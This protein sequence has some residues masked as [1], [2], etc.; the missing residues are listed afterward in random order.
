MITESSVIKLPLRMEKSSVGFVIDASQLYDDMT[1]YLEDRSLNRVHLN[2]KM[3][4]EIFK[5]AGTSK[6]EGK[7]A[8]IARVGSKE[9]FLEKFQQEPN[10]PIFEVVEIHKN[11]FEKR[12]KARKP[13]STF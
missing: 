11:K 8:T 6:I 9:K 12:N 2:G 7:L 4:G 10:N 5:M 13:N 1:V 3:L